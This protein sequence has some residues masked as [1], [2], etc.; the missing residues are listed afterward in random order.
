MLVSTEAIVLRGRKQ[1]D[2]S[3]ILSLYTEQYGKVDVIAKGARELKSKFGGALEM[4]SHTNAFFYKKEQ[5][6]LYLLSKA[7][8][9]ES[10]SKILNGLERIEAATAIVE[11]ILRAMHDE[12]EN[13]DIF[14]LVTTSL[15]AIAALEKEEAAP[16]ILLYF[17]LNFARIMGYR[18]LLHEADAISDGTARSSAKAFRT[19]TVFNVRTGE[20]HERIVTG[21]ATEIFEGI[22]VSPEAREALFYLDSASIEKAKALRLTE[23]AQTNL[24]ELFRAFFAE[25]IP[26]LDQR[27]LKSGKVFSGL[28]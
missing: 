4:F 12:E 9:V 21:E 6:G 22:V 10:N 28:S 20:L 8:T 3:K 16:S 23:G 15:R 26:G 24:T 19:K 25:H 17:Y 11:L 7:D 18:L 2:T 5:P 13:R 14:L 1:G 27:S